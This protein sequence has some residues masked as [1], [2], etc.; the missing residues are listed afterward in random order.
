[1]GA[2]QF[3]TLLIDFD[4]VLRSILGLKF[5]ILRL[6]YGQDQALSPQGVIGRHL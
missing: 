3:A 5:R 2:P 4:L 1:L 6:T